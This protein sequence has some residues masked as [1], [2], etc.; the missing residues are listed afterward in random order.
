MA[1][2]NNRDLGRSADAVR[3]RGRRLFSGRPSAGRGFPPFSEV[4]H[5]SAPKDMA[6]SSKL[7]L[8]PS[9]ERVEG[10][11]VRPCPSQSPFRYPSS[12]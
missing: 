8:I 10:P 2:I 12:A 6:Q 5:W 4:F 9:D 7:W 1:Y 11:G 3:E